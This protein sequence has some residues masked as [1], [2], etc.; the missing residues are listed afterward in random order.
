MHIGFTGTQRGMTV[1]QW[2]LLYRMMTK[3]TYGDTLYTSNVVRKSIHGHQGDCIG[4][5]YQFDSLCIAL[6]WAR[7]IHPPDNMSKR[8]RTDLITEYL[9]HIDEELPY[10]TRNHNIV[11][12]SDLMFACPGEHIQQLRS[13]TWST[14]RYAQSISKPLYVIYPNATWRFHGVMTTEIDMSSCDPRACITE[15]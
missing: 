7:C 9:D 14:I 13:G 11:D 2:H 6:Q 1:P 15:G 4:A 3:L 8:A 5:D 12:S 10:L